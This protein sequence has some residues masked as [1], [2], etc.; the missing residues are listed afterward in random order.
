MYS[1]KL[2]LERA[3]LSQPDSQPETQKYIISWIED[4]LD[5]KYFQI[6]CAQ[7]RRHMTDTK[8]KTAY[9]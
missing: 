3:E 6:E 5:T 9:A 2:E 7:R 1:R 8:W 4:S